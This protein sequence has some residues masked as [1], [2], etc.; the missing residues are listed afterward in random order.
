M[1]PSQMWGEVR[2]KRRARR[3]YG[4]SGKIMMQVMETDWLPAMLEMAPEGKAFTRVSIALF[5]LL[6]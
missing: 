2:Q 3:K 1:R 6:K 4:S 5:I